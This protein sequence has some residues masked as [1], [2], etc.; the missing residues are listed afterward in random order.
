MAD[1]S[2]LDIERLERPHPNLLKYFLLASILAGP[3][4]PLAALTSVLRYRA[5]RYHFDDEGVSMRW[6]LLFRKD[7]SL[8]YARLQDIHLESNA[9]ERWLG[10]GRVQLQTA[11]RVFCDHRLSV[12]VDWFR[13]PADPQLGNALVYGER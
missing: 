8:T 2:P 12:S 4:F 11:T 6:W 10:L 7:I 1:H 9:V 5:L 3:F 13:T